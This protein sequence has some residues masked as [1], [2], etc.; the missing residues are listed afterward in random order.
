MILLS[1]DPGSHVSGVA[2]WKDGKLITAAA[3]KNT[4][5]GSGPR[6]C[7]NVAMHI[8]DWVKKNILVK[9]VSSWALLDEIAVEWPQIYQRGDGKTKGDPNVNLPLAAV[10][11]AVAALF[12]R[13]PVIA[14]RPHDWKQ[15]IGKP[16][17][18]SETYAI[19]GKVRVRLS[20]EEL[21]AFEANWPKNV[22]H[23]WD[24]V[25]SVGVGLHHLGR[26]E[27]KRIF[28]RE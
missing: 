3:I 26:F 18:V 4:M 27:R 11:G 23:S 10:N 1:I 21:K 8:L 12:P 22:H 25:D 17:K 15:G 9:D 6:E 16:K 28:A 24:L 5:E 7:A 19:E 14:Y 2:L 13:V 20:S